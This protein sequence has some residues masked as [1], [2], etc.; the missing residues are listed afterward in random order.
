[1]AHRDKVAMRHRSCDRPSED[2]RDYC[3]QAHLSRAST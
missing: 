1:M 3:G 2:G